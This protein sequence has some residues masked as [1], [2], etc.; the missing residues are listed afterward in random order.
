[1]KQW[2]AL[3]VFLY[4]QFLMIE[5]FCIS[6]LISPKF[7]AKGSIDNKPGFVQVMA[8]CRTGDKPLTEPMQTQFIDAYVR[9]LGEMS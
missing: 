4:S 7:V 2:C 3:Y 6:I 8:W 9:Y 5:K 1:M